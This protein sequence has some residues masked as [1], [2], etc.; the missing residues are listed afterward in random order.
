VSNPEEKVEQKMRVYDG[1][2]FKEITYT[3]IFNENLVED[4]KLPTGHFI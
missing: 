4:V 1:K 3:P 2:I